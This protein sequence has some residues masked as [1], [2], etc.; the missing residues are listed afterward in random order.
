[1]KKIFILLSFLKPVRALFLNPYTQ[2]SGLALKE[3]IKNRFLNTLF[4]LGT[5]NEF[6]MAVL[7]G[8]RYTTV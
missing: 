5:Q 1:M 3:Y 7:S 2:E 6:A 8:Q 4:I